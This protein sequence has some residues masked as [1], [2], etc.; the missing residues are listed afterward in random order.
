MGILSSAKSFTPA[1]MLVISFP[2]VK[3]DLL[4]IANGLSPIFFTNS[5]TSL[6]INKID[7]GMGEILFCDIEN[8]DYILN[9]LDNVVGLS[10]KIYNKNK[11]NV[12][13]ALKVK[14]LYNQNFGSCGWS[15]TLERIK[16]IKSTKVHL[17]DGMANFQCV[18][19]DDHI[20]IG[21]P[22]IL[23]SY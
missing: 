5:K 7:N 18:E 20:V 8:L 4:T 1:D 11:A 10:I 19:K 6:K 22:I 14:N 2:I 12:L 17:L 23:G 3:H 21:M 16:V 15:G 13:Q 9:Q